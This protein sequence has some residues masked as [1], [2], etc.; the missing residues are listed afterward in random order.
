MPT[1]PHDHLRIKQNRT[2]TARSDLICAAAD[3]PLTRSL[4]EQNGGSARFVQAG[5]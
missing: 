5:G 3:P 1:R 4:G 2:L